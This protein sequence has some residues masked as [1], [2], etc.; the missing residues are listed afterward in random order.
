MAAVA[1]TRRPPSDRS[2]A[3]PQTGAQPRLVALDAAACRALPPDDASPESLRQAVARDLD[4]LQRL[5]A[6]R[7][8]TLLD[9]RVTAA[10]LIT[11]LNALSAAGGDWAAICDHL[12]LYRVEPPEG[13]LIT[14]YYQPVLP[15]SRVR[16]ERFRYP[17]YR[18][19][20]DL[21]DVDLRR[22]CPA[23]EAHV[24]QGRVAAG[25]LVPY[26]SRGEIDAGVLAGHDYE[27]AWLDDPVEAFF[28]HVQGSAL[29]RFDDGVSM[30][31][32]YSSANGRPYTGIG[33]VLI[34]QGK[35][36]REQLSLQ[37]LKDYLRAHP[38]EQPALF[39][40]NERYIFF[41]TVIT[42]PIGSLGVPLTAG[43]SIAADTHVYPPGALA[44][45][46]IGARAAGTGG[47]P[48]NVARFAVL[49]DTGA[50]ITGP[51]RLDVYWGT[52]AVAEAIAGD[53]RNP[54]ELYVVLPQ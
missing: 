30:Q 8:F 45:L 12:R 51:S 33:R 17:L 54:G 32:S 43:R 38:E 4:A 46:R 24:V 16:T 53:L 1:C 5:P 22:W 41:R 42:G 14:G 37:T 13:F 35:L 23:C 2:L 11:V 40:A 3:P 48:V 10:D 34:K 49:Q 31:V 25:K 20:D 29:L 7:A 36:A 50:G 26:Y 47:S 52:G 15:A 18:P 6:E 39:A 28:L 21:V 27:I 44:F 19:P 9:R